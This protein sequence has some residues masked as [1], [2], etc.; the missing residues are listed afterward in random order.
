MP[1]RGSRIDENVFVVRTWQERD[2]A[3]EAH[4]RASVTHVTSGDRRYFT[5]Y[6]ELHRFLDRWKK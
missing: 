2:G 3:G 6:D 4:W 1:I 5:T